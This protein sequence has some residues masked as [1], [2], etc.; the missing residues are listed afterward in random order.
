MRREQRWRTVRKVAAYGAALTLTP[1]LLIKVSWVVGTL[2]GLLPMGEGFSITEWVVLNTVTVGMAAIGIVLALVLARPWGGRLPAAPVIFCAWVGAGFLVP[3]I[4]YMLISQFLGAKGSEEHG[5]GGAGGDAGGG[6]GDAAMP[7]WEVALIGVGFLGM[8]VG[9]AVALPLYLCERW[10]QAFHGPV[11]DDAP[12]DG[13]AGAGALRPWPAGLAVAA[14]AVLGL[15]GLY[16]ACGG[17]A[18]IDHPGLRDLNPSLMT[19]NA[20]LWALIGGC[21]LWSLTTRRTTRRATRLP[22]W[23]PVTL[24]GVAS[25]SLFAWGGWKLPVTLYF[26]VVPHGDPQPQNLVVAASQH[27]VSI[28]TGATML[29]ALLRVLRRRVAGAPRDG[30]HPAT[31]TRAIEPRNFL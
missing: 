31:G 16:W 13:R 4:P 8:A 21:A 1:Y 14:A 22:L 3:V 11:G 24:T 5:N 28:A 2:L 20:G 29:Y 9:L 6:G 12:E 7:G 30:R 23:I 25:G 10:P 18:G 17:T 15:A 26:A 19:G 27:A